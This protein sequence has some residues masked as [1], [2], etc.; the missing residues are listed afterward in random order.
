[1]SINTDALLRKELDE[2]REL[3]KQAVHQAQHATE[4]AQKATEETHKA[5]DQLS[6]ARQQQG[7]LDKDKIADLELAIRVASLPSS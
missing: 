5:H 1:M 6:R 2:L 4:L 3:H 7:D